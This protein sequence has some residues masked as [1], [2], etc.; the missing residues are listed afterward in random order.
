[1]RTRLAALSLLGLV[2]ALLPLGAQARTQETV[3]VIKVTSVAVKAAVVKDVPPKGASKGDSVVQSDKLLNV[4]A[5]FGKKAGA[6]VGSDSGTMTF[7]SARAARFD[8]KAVLP[9]GTLTLAGQVLPLS[10]GG[11]SIP[12]TGGTG[13]F[14]GAHGI[15]RVGPGSA[16]S[17]N[18]YTLTFP[19]APV[20]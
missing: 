20:A 2:A 9:G 3:L 8:G 16:R 4:A 6:T 13:R 12:V 7:T 5:Q 15:L 17:L 1:V 10:G 14:R 18:T 19:L 11:V